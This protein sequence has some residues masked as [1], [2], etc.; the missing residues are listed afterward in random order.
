VIWS[1]AP[2]ETDQQSV[3]LTGWRRG[4][5]ERERGVWPGWST[6]PSARPGLG[7]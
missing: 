6:S 4:R 2:C 1:I 3:R 5:N 7:Q